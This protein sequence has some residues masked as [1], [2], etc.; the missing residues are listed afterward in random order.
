MSLQNIFRFFYTVNITL[1]LILLIF[2]IEREETLSTLRICFLLAGSSEI[3]SVS[4]S[5]GWK[6]KAQAAMQEK[7]KERESSGI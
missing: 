1:S 4:Y 5:L 6:I 2:N 7:V 3:F